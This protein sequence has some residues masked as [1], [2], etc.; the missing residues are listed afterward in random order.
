M[1]DVIQ[2]IFD[3]SPGANPL[4]EQINQESE[5]LMGVVSQLQENVNEKQ[6][7]LSALSA[8]VQAQMTS[9]QQKVAEQQELVESEVADCDSKVAELRRGVEEIKDGVTG[10]LEAAQ[11]QMDDFRGHV[12]AGRET[13]EAA[14]EAAQAVIS[15]VHDHIQTGREA[16]HSATDFANEQVDGFQAKIDET[17]Q[18]TETT[19]TNLLN[20]MEEGVRDTGAKVEEMVGMS[21]EEMHSGFMQGMELVQGNVLQAGVD[22]VLDDLQGRIEQQANQ[23]ID[24][25]VDELVGAL[26]NVRE[27]IFGNAEE[28]GLERQATEAVLD[29]LKE[30]LS[31]LFD[32]VDHIKD[33]ASMVGID[34]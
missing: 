28:A 25:I 1:R 22:T 12:D 21:F 29:A 20:Q 26:G 13:I 11:Q 24:Q 7:S 31:P 34:I 23:L 5:T 6:S 8:R 2:Q 10:A 19:A 4:L 27:S 32:A 18:F 16:L 30:I 33:M 14:N 3:V 9:L 15:E 17:M